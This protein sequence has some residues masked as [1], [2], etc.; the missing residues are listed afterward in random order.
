VRAKVSH[1]VGLFVPII[2]AGLTFIFKKKVSSCAITS[3]LANREQPVIKLKSDRA[4]RLDCGCLHC[5]KWVPVFRIAT[6]FGLLC[7]LK[8]IE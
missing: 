6:G 4:Y 7:V 1:Y 8:V 2:F 5:K 3:D